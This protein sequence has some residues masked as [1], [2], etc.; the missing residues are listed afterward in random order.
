ME[1]DKSWGSWKYGSS[2]LDDVAYSLYLEY[3]KNN[4]KPG[5]VPYTSQGLFVF[6]G[7]IYK[8]Y[9]DEAELIIRREKILKIKSKIDEYTKS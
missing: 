3:R 9:Y 6:G 7:G 1:L 2:L 4:T 8:R 5:Y